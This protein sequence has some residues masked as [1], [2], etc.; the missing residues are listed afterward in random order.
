M[1]VSYLLLLLRGL[2]I[3]F[4]CGEEC[5]DR[6]MDTHMPENDPFLWTFLGGP[7]SAEPTT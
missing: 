4:S 1:L 3:Y 5:S 7:C 6:I 2:F